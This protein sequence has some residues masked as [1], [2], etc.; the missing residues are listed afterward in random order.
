[1]KLNKEFI[2]DVCVNK[3]LVQ[4]DKRLVKIDKLPLKRD[5][6]ITSIENKKTMDPILDKSNMRKTSNF[7]K[8]IT[9]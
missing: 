5:K 4:I 2:K 7:V 3:L 9:S 8:S 6:N 1:M